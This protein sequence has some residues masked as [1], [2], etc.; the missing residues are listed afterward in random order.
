MKIIKNA[1]AKKATKSSKAKASKP[2]PKPRK[3][4]DDARALAFASTDLKIAMNTDQIRF[5]RCLSSGR[6]IRMV[7]IKAFCGLSPEQKYSG[8]FLTALHSLIAI[9]CVQVD[10]DQDSRAFEYTITAKGKAAL[11]DAT[12]SAKVLAKSS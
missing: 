7:A 5:L 8:T 11:A 12:K 9:K 6:P 10:K 1:T 2:Q 4:R 3:A